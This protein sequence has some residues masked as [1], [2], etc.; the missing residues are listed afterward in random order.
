MAE[1]DINILRTRKD[2]QQVERRMQAEYLVEFYRHLKV[3]QNLRLGRI[4]SALYQD[5]PKDIPRRLFLVKNPRADAVVISPTTMYLLEFAL[6]MNWNHVAQLMYYQEHLKD[7]A[8]LQPYSSRV[9][10]LRL[11]YAVY[12]PAAASYATKNN[13]DIEQYVRPW[14]NPRIAKIKK[15][16]LEGTRE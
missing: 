4:K 10:K 8:D 5:I 15:H 7:T 2:Y 16:Y 13:I 9:I 1:K 12:E 14:M 11:I 6:E 3:F